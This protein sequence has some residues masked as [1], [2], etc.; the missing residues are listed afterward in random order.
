MSLLN[1]AS[2]VMKWNASCEHII[3]LQICT[4]PKRGLSKVIETFMDMKFKISGVDGWIRPYILY[5][6][7]YQVRGFYISIGVVIT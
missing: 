5:F 1:P 3:F 4:V 2:N 7:R 6:L